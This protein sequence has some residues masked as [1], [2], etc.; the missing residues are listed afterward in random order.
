V[1]PARPLS[2]SERRDWIRLSRTQNASPVTFFQLLKRFGSPALA[3]SPAP[4]HLHTTPNRTMPPLPDSQVARVREAPSP[5]PMAIDEIARASRLSV[6][7]CAAILAEVA[8]SGEAV[9]L[10]GGLAVRA[11]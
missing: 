1:S 10:S 8:L 2:D 4:K 9:P 7:R 3:T 5:H 6:A 11:V